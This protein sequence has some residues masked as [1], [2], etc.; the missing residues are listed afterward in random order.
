MSI[1]EVGCL[2]FIGLYWEKRQK[3]WMDPHVSGM[4][5]LVDRVAIYCD[6]NPG[7]KGGLGAKIKNSVLGL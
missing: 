6:E 1:L 4:N 2:D 3:L 5:S 7:G